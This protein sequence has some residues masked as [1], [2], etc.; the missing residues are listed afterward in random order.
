MSMELKDIRTYIA[1]LGISTDEHTYI[2]FL[3]N[4]FDCSIGVYSRAMRDRPVL[5]VGGWTSASYDIKAVSVLVHW[6]RKK[7]ESESAAI[8]L[9]E[10]LKEPPA[11]IGGYPVQY[12]RLLVPEP[13][14][15]GT[16]S[17]GVYE[18]VIEFDVYYD[19]TLAVDT[20]PGESEEN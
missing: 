9:F 18:Y 6:N 2:G 10:A 3:D 20:T 15:V 5:A 16:D 14:D 8:R 13:I 17:K 11:T 12:L 4:K 19:K 1:S 7:T